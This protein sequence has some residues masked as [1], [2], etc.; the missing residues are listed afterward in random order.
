[1]Q[2]DATPDRL[3]IPA[4]C[5]M[6]VHLRQGALLNV[7]KYS[8]EY[9]Q[10]ILAMPNTNPPLFRARDVEEYRAD[11]NAH[12]K[13]YKSEMQ[14]NYTIY[15]NDDTTKDDI[16]LAVANGVIAG[17]VYPKAAT[18][19][20]DWGVTNYEKLY[21]VF[22]EM[23]THGMVLCLHGEHPAPSPDKTVLD[24]E[25][26]FVSDILPGIVHRFPGLT[27]ICE[28]ITTKESVETVKALPNVFAT[29]TAHHLYLTIDDILAYGIQPLNY[30]KPVA[31]L[32][33]D[34]IAVRAA[35][36]WCGDKFF[37]GSDS[38]PHDES[39]KFCLCGAAGCFTAPHAYSLV[40]EFFASHSEGDY[41]GLVS[42]SPIFNSF[43]RFTSQNA[44]DIYKLGPSRRM[45]TLYRQDW[46]Y[47]KTISCGGKMLPLFW[48][49]KTGK[50]KLV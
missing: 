40:T 3:H 22:Q 36:L 41:I 10:H 30:C 43:L 25:R 50:W 20:S 23:E 21:D 13:S 14:V 34:L 46:Q 1:M 47:A 35:A 38:A 31:K 44:L 5:D 37:F 49:G 32:K 2:I 6:H 18:T 19:H 28:H 16:A 17:K 39:A 33:D 4:F 8:A 45:I 24:W 29:I 12:V 9:C 11:V 15:I 7:V 26:Q 48:G 27:I 42:G